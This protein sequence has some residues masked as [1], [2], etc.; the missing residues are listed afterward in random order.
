MGIWAWLFVIVCFGFVMYMAFHTRRYIRDAVDFLA[1]G[2]VGGRYV[3]SVAGMESA[4]GLMALI[5]LVE[6]K[7]QSGLSLEFWN[8]FLLPLGMILSLTGFC[9]YRYRQTRSLSLGEFLERRYNR[10]LRIFAM[11]LR[12]SAEMLTNTIGPA[13][14]ARVFIYLFDWPAKLHFWGLTVDTFMLVMAATLLLALTIISCGGMLALL[15]TD[16]LQGL[17]CYPIFVIFTIYVFCNFSWDNEIVPALANRVPNESFLNPFDISDL[18]EFNAFAIFVTI[19]GTI[20]NRGIWY[21]GG[22]T[23]SARTPHEQKMSGILGELRGAFSSIMTLLFAL[24]VIVIFHHPNHFTKAHQIR[25]EL[26]RAVVED[27]ISDPAQAAKVNNAIAKLPEKPPV[28]DKLALKHNYDTAYMN[29]FKEVM[30]QTGSESTGNA[31]LQEYRTLYHQMMF[32]VTMREVLPEWL[33][34]VLCLLLIMLM[35]STDDS[36]MFSSSLTITQDIIIPLYGKPLPVKKQLAL[37]RILT[38]LVAIIFFFGSL[39]LSQLDYIR[40]YITIVVS[41]WAGGAGPVVLFGLYSRFGNTKGAFTSLILGSSTS[42]GGVLIQR[43]WA[44]H[45]Y[46]FLKRHNWVDGVGNFLE[47]VSRPFNPYIKWE[48]NAVKCPVNSYEFF[49]LAMLIGITGYV[50]VSLLTNRGKRYD[51][52]ALLHRNEED[53]NQKKQ[54]VSWVS[55]LIGITPE[56]TRGDKIIAWFVFCYSVMWRCGIAF[57]G[58][59]AW[60]MISKWKLES[61]GTY[62][63]VTLFAIPCA[64]GVFTTFWFLIGGIKDMRQLF[65]DLAARQIDENDN[66]FVTKQ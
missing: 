64:L 23:S 8:V 22:Q 52:D 33:M 13:I 62:F 10:G 18:K 58:V 37:A 35:V 65:R 45:V 66:G 14:S 32:S 42:L 20:L 46:P 3:L 34:A 12:T 50:T 38:L 21:G 4:L 27:I 40:L 11:I 25:Q 30:H 59:L 1:A 44:D 15:V 51:L 61:W 28:I 31:K 56:Y 6:M 7:Y 36:K 29:T 16:C 24:M 60:N 41:I 47:T 2:R 57:L 55:K 19:F 63:F 54:K 49:F 26:S 17:L 43:N 53:E 39:F 5:G 48:M 9:L